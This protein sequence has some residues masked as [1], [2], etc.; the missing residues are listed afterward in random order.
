M[1]DV[2]V[3][4]EPKR[5]LL[6][7]WTCHEESGEQVIDSSRSANHG[8]LEGTVQRVLCSRDRLDPI[9]TASEQLVDQNFVLLRDWRV[10]FERKE[11]REMTKADLLLADP[12][13]RGIARRLG[14]L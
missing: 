4:D 13:V 11:G 12:A 14:V 1:N 6:A 8:T 9:M 3:A 5:K 10:E 7:Q 2:V